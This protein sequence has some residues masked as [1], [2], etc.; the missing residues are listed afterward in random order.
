MPPAKGGG[1]EFAWFGG[2]SGPVPDARGRPLWWTSLV[3]N[4]PELEATL[5][6]LDP[7]RELSCR[8]DIPG[9]EEARL[10]SKPGALLAARRSA[11]PLAF[12]F[13]AQESMTR[14]VL[15]SGPDGT[16]AAG[17][18][19]VLIRGPMAGQAVVIQAE[20]ERAVA[21]RDG[22]AD[23]HLLDPGGSHV[24][25]GWDPGTG[26]CG[27]LDGLVQ[28][29]ALADWVVRLKRPVEFRARARLPGG[30]VPARASLLLWPLSQALPMQTLTAS[31]EG[32]FASPPLGLDGYMAQA[33]ITD[34]KGASYGVFGRASDLNGRDLVPEKSR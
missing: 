19:V 31:R 16:P 15:V 30:A 29:A 7:G 3:W 12:A 27:R 32:D 21:G 6:G 18:W 10:D 23:L 24:V 28:T 22:R 4:A 34:A 25:V 8:L 14:R 17:A 13:P 20:L 26:A 9:R 33:M 1:R 5:R 2:F 11:S